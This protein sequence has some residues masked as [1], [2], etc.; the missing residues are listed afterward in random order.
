[1]MID[2]YSRGPQAMR[3][4]LSTGNGHGEPDVGG[5]EGGTIIRTITGD[6]NPSGT[7]TT[8]NVTE[9]INMLVKVIPFSLG[10]LREKGVVKKQDGEGMDTYRTGSPVPN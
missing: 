1:M 3:H 10:V 6:T 8:T 2:V 7:A 4:H 5:L 9:V